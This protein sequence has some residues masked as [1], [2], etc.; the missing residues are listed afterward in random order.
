[1]SHDE[2]HH[3]WSSPGAARV[4][5]EA[6]LSRTAV[7]LVSTA[8]A[9]IRVPVLGVR[10][11]RSSHVLLPCIGGVPLAGRRVEV[12]AAVEARSITIRAAT[13][14]RKRPNI[15]LRLRLG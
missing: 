8:V 4:T 10:G 3:R 12:V 2:A 5:I 7:V 9:A 1:M 11:A 14:G 15:P 6:V 13:G